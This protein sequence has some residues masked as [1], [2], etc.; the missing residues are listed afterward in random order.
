MYKSLINE[1]ESKVYEISKSDGS[2]PDEDAALLLKN[3]IDKYDS[4]SGKIEFHL[5]FKVNNKNIVQKFPEFDS[6]ADEAA[7]MF[8][9]NPISK[10]SIRAMDVFKLRKNWN[11]PE[12][13]DYFGGCDSLK[14]SSAILISYLRNKTISGD[15]YPS[16]FADTSASRMESTFSYLNRIGFKF[17]AEDVKDYKSMISDWAK[18]YSR[19]SKIATYDKDYYETLES[20]AKNILS[21]CEKV[22]VPEPNIVQKSIRE[23]RNIFFH[24]DLSTNLPQP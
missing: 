8:K 3:V 13:N 18:E 1:N 4:S 19:L 20:R 12:H 5:D 23:I 21:L 14:I 2:Y 9:K 10:Y 17:K 11:N 15:N 7:T 22:T 16:F 6:V 24:K